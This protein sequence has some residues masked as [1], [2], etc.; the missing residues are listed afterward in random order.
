MNLAEIKKQ[1]EAKKNMKTFNSSTSKGKI[2]ELVIQCNFAKDQKAYSDST[3]RNTI[4]DHH[5][6]AT[7]RNARNGVDHY[8]YFSFVRVCS[9]KAKYARMSLVM[10]DGTRVRLSEMGIHKLVSEML[11][12]GDVYQREWEALVTGGDFDSWGIDPETTTLEE[13]FALA[14]REY[15]VS[16]VLQNTI[17]KF[18]VSA[19][20]AAVME[21]EQFAYKSICFHIPFNGEMS[22]TKD[23]RGNV[24]LSVEN[25]SISF[26]TQFAKDAKIFIP[27]DKVTSAMQAAAAYAQEFSS[28]ASMFSEGLSDHK[29]QKKALAPAKG[30]GTGKCARRKK[31]IAEKAL[32]AEAEAMLQNSPFA[33]EAAEAPVAE[34]KAPVVVEEKKE[35]LPMDIFGINSG[36]SK[37]KSLDDL[38]GDDIEADPDFDDEE[39]AEDVF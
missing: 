22:V 29:K 17:F 32:L 19:D 3:K 6:G 13:D 21:D 35:N 14:F 23:S 25:G 8:S 30:Q 7:R 15:M 26:S 1:I 18:E 16:Q 5:N 38:F 39:S 9:N 4:R 12:M 20:L 11:D 28:P 37:I 24:Y 27:A 31:M 34:A 10:E 36:G 2:K 33:S